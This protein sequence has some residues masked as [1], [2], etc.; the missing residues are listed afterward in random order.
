MNE[1]DNG[2]F[3]PKE[4]NALINTLKENFRDN[5]RYTYEKKFEFIRDPDYLINKDLDDRPVLADGVF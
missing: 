2:F 1:Y 4:Y 3:K 5:L